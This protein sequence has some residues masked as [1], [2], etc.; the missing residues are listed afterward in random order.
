MTRTSCIYLLMTAL[1]LT[2]PRTGMAEA[3]KLPTQSVPG[4]K[5]VG[6]AEHPRLFFR[7]SDLPELR[8]RANT[9]EGRE[10][11]QRL[12]VTL[13]G[14]TAMPEVKNSHP[15]HLA[16]LKNE[17]YP[18]GAYSISH[19][20]G[21]GMLYQLTGDK[22]YADLARQSLEWGF[23]GVRDRDPQA[24]YSMIYP[25]E[26][27][28]VGP[29]LAWTALAYDLCYEAWDEAFRSKVANFI[30]N[31]NEVEGVQ[32]RKAKGNLDVPDPANRKTRRITMDGMMS[33]ASHNPSS[34]HW[35]SINGGIGIA[36]LAIEGDPG[37]DSTK[38]AR[39][40]SII[41]ERMHRAILDGYGT[42]GMFAEGQGPSHMSIYPAM[43]AYFQAVRSVKGIE[44]YVADSPLTWLTKRWI[45]ETT[46]DARGDAWYPARSEL[47]GTQ[48]GNSAMMGTQGSMSHS[49][50][51]SIGFG[52]LP[53]KL[54]PAF[55]WLY[56]N[57]CKSSDRVGYDSMN[58]PH[59][60]VMA[61]INW[62]I[63][64]KAV[65]PQTVIPQ[66]SYDPKYG[67]AMFRS[68]WDGPGDIVVTSF[69]T[70]N[71][72]TY[73][74][75]P[76]NL[77]LMVGGKGGM[78]ELRGPRMTGVPRYQ[79]IKDGVGS[80]TWETGGYAVDFS[81][82]SG[83]EGVVVYTGRFL[84]DQAYTDR[85]LAQTVRIGDTNVVILT[86]ST[87]GKH[88][89]AM[90]SGDTVQLGGA[91][92]QLVGMEFQIEASGTP[93]LG[94][95]VL[96][97]YEAKGMEPPVELTEAD[98]QLPTTTYAG[99]SF[100]FDSI[101]E[102][103][104]V[105][106]AKEDSGS[107]ND[108]ALYNSQLVHGVL[109][110]AITFQKPDEG[111]ATDWIGGKA[112]ASF[113]WSAPKGEPVSWSWWVQP[114]KPLAGYG[115]FFEKANYS[116]PNKPGAYH[117][118]WHPGPML[119]WGS[120]DI[121]FANKAG[122][123]IHLAVVFDLETNSVIRY[124]NGEEV[125]RQSVKKG[126]PPHFK[127]PL[128]LGRGRGEGVRHVSGEKFI[129]DEFRIYRGALQPGEVLA[130]FQE[131][132]K[133]LKEGPGDRNSAPIASFSLGHENLLP[134]QAVSFDA[135]DSIDPEKGDLSYKW[136]F[137]DGRTATGSTVAHT[138]QA[139]GT[140]V[141]TLTVMDPTG[142][143]GT[144]QRDLNVRIRPPVVRLAVDGDQPFAGIHEEVVFDAN[145]SVDPNGGQLSFQYSKEGKVLSTE[146]TLTLKGLP[147]GSHRIGLKVSSSLGAETTMIR[148][149]TVPDSEGYFIANRLSDLLP[150]LHYHYSHFSGKNFKLFPYKSRKQSLQENASP[151]FVYF[152][153]AITPVKT[154]TIH[155][156]DTEA[157]RLK[158][159]GYMVYYSGFLKVPEDG[160]YSFTVQ[161]I[162]FA[163]L[164]IA[165]EALNYRKDVLVDRKTAY[166]KSIKL[167]KG[168]H[169]FRLYTGG[170]VL[171][172]NKSPTL[173]AK[174]LWSGPGFAQRG[175]MPSD[176]MRSMTPEERVSLG[177]PATFPGPDLEE[178]AVNS[179]LEN[180]KARKGSL[181]VEGENG[182]F[183][184]STETEPVE[185]EWVDW[186]LGNG[187]QTKDGAVT[188]AYAPGT[189]IVSYRH[190]KADRSVQMGSARI[191]VPAHH[192]KRAIGIDMNP[193]NR[194][195]LPSLN[196]WD[197]AGVFPQSNWNSLYQGKRK[198]V[199]KDQ[200]RKKGNLFD[201][202]GKPVRTEIHYIPTFRSII[203]NPGENEAGNFRLMSRAEAYST[204]KV[205][206]IPYTTYDAIIYFT[207]QEGKNSEGVNTCSIQVNGRS[208]DVA[209]MTMR[210]GNFQGAYLRS[211][212]DTV[213][214][215]LLIEGL[216]KP[217]LDI[218]VS[219]DL[220]KKPP[221]GISAV[222]IV[223]V[224]Q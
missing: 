121:P 92:I 204:F 85:N 26:Q 124:L 13:G 191:Q 166:S 156:I 47:F 155:G 66:S 212:P 144:A 91:K 132:Q 3:E 180:R 34:N 73:G 194:G 172:D 164:W 206:E 96:D 160:E 87:S 190:H 125:A 79:P 76:T 161:G 185:G 216:T 213:G 67:Y 32:V 139:E 142:K 145:Q 37:V 93:G 7:K 43:L 148:T 174:V 41:E 99:F 45:L 223:E 63:G 157:L 143:T 65:N 25:T 101:Y 128:Y 198:K 126:S 114:L 176:F 89:K 202:L 165:G 137:G 120:W 27:L 171:G 71:I 10:I 14:G 105:R 1:S 100:N 220:K 224:K 75:W 58:Y 64:Q 116:S 222:Q 113:L 189:Y 62:P 129:I 106:Y 77:N 188:A 52:A 127:E 214:N 122:E 181:R 38:V 130:L 5:P 158:R 147:S 28:R 50:W 74:K 69:E 4:F 40:L 44:Y 54:R 83:V 115:L 177:K 17:F 159:Q 24:R 49:G 210:E 94:E 35:G 84:G 9:P 218:A 68:G 186:D 16:Y 57:I 15:A 46:T 60:P 88:P 29:M 102:L 12:K 6:K 82:A 59:L 219:V 119:N 134:G 196:P 81:G 133:A 197:T 42:N 184:L 104:G 51:F 136:T 117:A 195:G 163:M 208:Y 21:F 162:N 152:D 31:Y 33:K 201:N 107:G 95:S 36:L 112:P 23:E 90:V 167:R 2:F 209:E 30:L 140:Y 187:R 138:Y 215:Y 108:M 150:G 173:F 221:V 205:Q 175:M 22:K 217:M 151:R 123:W 168:L 118:G 207:I 19:G 39:Y 183:R 78:L 141:V 61:L 20:A 8:R 110:G 200:V 146:P 178:I 179:T 80:L 53:E 131:G 154:G 18:E 55:L 149:I 153:D 97:G 11:V 170:S 72:K 193:P 111:S 109:D 192:G 211:G 103:G 56:E 98:I 169:R 135:S 86:L 48:Y 199:P 70:R 182:I 203:N